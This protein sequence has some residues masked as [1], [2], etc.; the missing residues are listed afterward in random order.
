MS[1]DKA[2]RAHWDGTWTENPLPA[3]MDPRAAGK[4][5]RVVRRFHDYFSRM[6][7]GVPTSGQRLVEIGCARSVWLP[8]FAREFGFVVEGLDYS[9]I[10]CQQAR[11]ILRREDVE[12]VVT[13][14]DMFAPPAVLCGRF[15]VVV[16][17]GVAEHFEDTA[18]CIAAMAQ[19]LRAGGVIFTIVPNMA[20]LIGL[21]QKLLNRPVYDIHVPL[22]VDALELAH[23]R[24]GL[25]IVKSEYFL[26]PNFGIPNL[27]GVR[28]SPTWFAKKA[29]LAALS[30][31]SV[32][33]GQVEDS[34][35]DMPLS[36]WNSSY[37]LCAARKPTA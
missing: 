11:E 13:C 18:T 37:V 34:L 3:R 22:D 12:A 31:G 6:L 1:A 5:N 30:R 9:E 27:T 35:G 20:G 2:G 19:L 32:A 15:D 14:A 21:T 33:L 4:R 29:L 26:S 28:R 8:Y 36:R 24:A 10:G 16:S 17:F 23:G 25:S 7:S